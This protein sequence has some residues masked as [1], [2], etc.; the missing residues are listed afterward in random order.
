[1]DRGF[2]HES[3][4]IVP[5]GHQA[6]VFI[7]AIEVLAAG[8]WEVAFRRRGITANGFAFW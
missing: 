4:Q 5:R 1:M 7:S 8:T 6:L 2:L 3:S